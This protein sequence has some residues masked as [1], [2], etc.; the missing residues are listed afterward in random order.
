MN[1]NFDKCIAINYKSNSQKIRVMSEFW[2]VKNLF[3]PCCGNLHIEKMQ[4]NFPVADILCKNCGEI[5]EL[6]S[7]KNFIGSKITDGA[8]HTMI[9]R[10]ISNKNPQFL[11]RVE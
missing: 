7:K 9:A 1:L 8:Y 6:K 2:I 5:F 4:N 3:C 11:G 10:I